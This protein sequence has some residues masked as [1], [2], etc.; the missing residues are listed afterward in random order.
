MCVS[1]ASEITRNKGASDIRVVRV[2]P[3]VAVAKVTDPGEDVEV[4]VHLAV[5]RRRED[6]HLGEGVGDGADA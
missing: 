5:Q 6:A 1:S 3:V 2:S 4:L